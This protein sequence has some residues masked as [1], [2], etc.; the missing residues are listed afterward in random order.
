MKAILTSIL[1][2]LMLSPALVAQQVILIRHARV[3]QDHSGW[4]SA[5]T[6]A[7][8]RAAYD[9][10]P[11]HQFNADTVLAQLPRRI[12][13]TVYV[14]ALPRSIATGALLFGDSATL[15]SNALFNEFELHISR[16]PLYLPY[17]AWTSLSRG[18][19]LLGHKHK[20]A[21]SFDEAKNRVE[22]AVNFIEHKAQQ[23]QQVI[24]VTHG[25]INRNIA[26]TLEKRGWKLTQNNGTENLGATVLKKINYTLKP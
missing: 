5:K 11:I 23:Q 3:F 18:L 24:L 6:A 8:M 15:V 13:D 2:V 17:K 9:T 20:T 4:M 7:E 10:A 14:S 25:F 16:L 26:N 22:E 12:S 19:W 1:L 21:E